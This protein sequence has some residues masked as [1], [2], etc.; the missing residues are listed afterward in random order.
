MSDAMVLTAEE[1]SHVIGQRREVQNKFEKIFFSLY[2]LKQ[3]GDDSYGG[4]MDAIK[5]LKLQDATFDTNIREE[6][7]NI[8]LHLRQQKLETQ[9][10]KEGRGQDLHGE[11]EEAKMMEWISEQLESGAASEVQLRLPATRRS[12]TGGNPVVAN[13]NMDYEDILK[14][15]RQQAQKKAGDHV[16]CGN[17]RA[18]VEK[19]KGNNCVIRWDKKDVD[20]EDTE[21]VPM[22]DLRVLERAHPALAITKDRGAVD[23]K[24]AKW[25]H[26]SNAT[27]ALAGLFS[28][29]ADGESP[30][31]LEPS[32]RS[33]KRLIEEEQKNRKNKMMLSRSQP[34]AQPRKKIN[35][36]SKF[37]SK[38]PFAPLGYK[39]KC[40]SKKAGEQ[41]G[42]QF[43][44]DTMC[45][46]EVEE[47]SPG[48][49]FD[50][51]RG[52]RITH[53]SLREDAPPFSSDEGV[54]S[55]EQLR[56]ALTRATASETVAIR[57]EQWTQ[58]RAVEKKRREFREKL[59]S[60]RNKV[61]EH[62][63]H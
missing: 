60:N 36:A 46:T 55:K 44:P 2:L 24:N 13:R 10:R 17:R 26:V 15:R 50:E 9:W 8:E 30:A 38:P 35:V 53:V 25:R 19:V 21:I 37:M 12:E 58:R 5:E 59:I 28:R 18:T 1:Q 47:N 49:A 7:G 16:M 34:S 61:K 6:L 54:H 11:E 51:F 56:R 29:A 42:L 48:S 52:M 45:L 20:G 31:F 63:N 41:L 62:S 33:R 39:E 3:A 4:P 14:T 57:F 40:I 22:E 27:S 23:V 32:A 43:E